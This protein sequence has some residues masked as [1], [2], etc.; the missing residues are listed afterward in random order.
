MGLW[1]EVMDQGGIM[2]P[3]LFFSFGDTISQKINFGT[4]LAL[5]TT[6]KVILNN[7]RFLSL[8]AKGRQISMDIIVEKF[9]IS[10]ILSFNGAMHLI[11][12]LRAFK[13]HIEFE[14]VGFVSNFFPR[15]LLIFV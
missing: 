1:K 5:K 13:I 7:F 14:K 3:I 15:F 8:S 11:W 10:K 2:D 6:W 9:K 4:F 12:K